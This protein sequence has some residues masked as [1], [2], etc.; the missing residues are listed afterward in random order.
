MFCDR[1][2]SS[3]RLR[4]DPGSWATFTGPDWVCSKFHCPIY[5]AERAQ[6]IEPEGRGLTEESISYTFSFA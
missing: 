6:Y 3:H 4:P 1:R 5:D 2:F